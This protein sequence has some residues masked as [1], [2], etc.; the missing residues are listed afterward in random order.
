MTSILSMPSSGLAERA[1]ALRSAF[2][3]I[4]ATPWRAD[5]AANTDFI[6]IRVG[7]ERCAIRLAEVTGLFADKKI[8]RVPGTVAGLLGIASFRGALL[9]VHHLAPPDAATTPSATSRLGTA[10]APRWLVV[11]A[12]APV[13]FAFEAF[14]SHLRA[15][16]DAILPRQS[17]GDTRGFAPNFV[18]AGGVVRPIIDLAAIVATLDVAQAASPLSRRRETR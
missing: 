16:V 9:P 14:E 5:V 11:A 7:D 17:H 18:R 8:T 13:A 15:P 6:A 4:F 12:A 3:E 10:A 1:A 2:D